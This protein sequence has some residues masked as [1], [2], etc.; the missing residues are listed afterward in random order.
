[1]KCKSFFGPEYWVLVLI[2]NA[3][4]KEDNLRFCCQSFYMHYKASISC[5][6]FNAFTTSLKRSFHKC[7]ERMVSGHIYIFWRLQIYLKK[8][9]IQSSSWELFQRTII[10]LK[11]YRNYFV[12]QLPVGRAQSLSW[13][14]ID[15]SVF[16]IKG[17]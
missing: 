12:F 4:L 3:G 17:R 2:N 9:T 8:L 13:T 7:G 10:M 15:H 16:L 11:K 1:M 14:F 6:K 5:S